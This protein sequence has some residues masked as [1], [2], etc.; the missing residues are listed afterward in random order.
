[1]VER[2]SHMKDARCF[3]CKKYRALVT[4][5]KSL[6]KKLTEKAKSLRGNQKYQVKISLDYQTKSL[7]E[8]LSTGRD[9][10]LKKI[11]L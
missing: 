3:P 8:L 9:G 2:Y 1:M 5:R 7:E 4:Y 11:K 10:H 6:I